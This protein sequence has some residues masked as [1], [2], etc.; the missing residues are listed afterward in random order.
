MSP[1][2]VDYV[3]IALI[4]VIVGLLVP[5]AAKLWELYAESERRELPE[6]L[7]DLAPER[8][9]GMTV[10]PAPFGECAELGGDPFVVP[11]E[12]FAAILD[13]IK[14]TSII[15]HVRGPVYGK[16]NIRD[17][18]GSISVTVFAKEL[19]ISRGSIVVYCRGGDSERFK[20][21]VLSAYRAHK[22]K[23]KTE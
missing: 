6:W 10:S 13:S 15:D 20:G 1:K 9:V 4:L 23:W 5:G 18:D 8:V 17:A 14:A 3:V 21:A 19:A 7:S 11:E 12:H 22:E 16:V 2:L